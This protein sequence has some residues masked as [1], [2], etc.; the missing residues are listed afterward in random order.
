M[1][2]L[3]VQLLKESEGGPF[4]TTGV[5][6]VP[7]VDPSIQ[8]GALST[9]KRIQGRISWFVYAYILLGKS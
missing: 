9:G 3:G 7:L 4:E 1:K 2:M 5:V 8:T 6:W